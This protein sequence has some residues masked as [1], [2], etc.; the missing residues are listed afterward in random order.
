MEMDELHVRNLHWSP[1]LHRY[2]IHHKIAPSH[3]KFKSMQK[4]QLSKTVEQIHTKEYTKL[5]SQ[6][7]EKVRDI[8]PNGYVYTLA[9][10]FDLIRVKPPVVEKDRS[11]DAPSQIIINFY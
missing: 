4:R 9:K 6:P 7:H 11:E 3:Q 8:L 1:V 10:R 2:E 5:T